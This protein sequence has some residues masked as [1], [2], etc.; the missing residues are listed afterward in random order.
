[1]AT[2]S[3]VN[4]GTGSVFRWYIMGAVGSD[5]RND[6]EATRYIAEETAFSFGLYQQLL[7]D[8]TTGYA[9]RNG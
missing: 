3:S 2:D 4:G 5:A 6:H 9:L 1:M 8:I 7:E